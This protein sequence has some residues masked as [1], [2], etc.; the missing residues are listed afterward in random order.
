MHN[1]KVQSRVVNVWGLAL[2]LV[3]TSGCNGDKKDE[4]ETILIAQGK[5]V[6]RFDTFGDEQLWTDQLKLH[7]V[8]ESAVSP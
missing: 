3:L 7:Q 2:I 6:F 5:E 1:K 4:T 8:I